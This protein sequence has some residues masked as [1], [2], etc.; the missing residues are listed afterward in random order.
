MVT[1]ALNPEP[2]KRPEAEDGS[3]G[4]RLGFELRPLAH[5]LPDRHVLRGGL[6][7]YRVHFQLLHF[8]AHSHLPDVPEC[9]LGDQPVILQLPGP[10]RR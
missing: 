9:L 10:L 1:T 5:N 6:F 3:R 7:A 8:S 2:P 4:S